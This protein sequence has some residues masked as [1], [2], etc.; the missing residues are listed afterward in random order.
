MDDSGHKTVAISMNEEKEFK[1]AIAN[2]LIFY[3]NGKIR[4]MMDLI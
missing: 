1:K 4:Q 2:D 3:L